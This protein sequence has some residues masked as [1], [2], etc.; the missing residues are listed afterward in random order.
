MLTD[1][2]KLIL[3]EN[4][5][6]AMDFY[7][8][9]GS[10][11]RIK[12]AKYDSTGLDSF[13][14]YLY[15][16]KVNNMIDEK[17]VLISLLGNTSYDGV[18]DIIANTADEFREVFVNTG[19]L[20]VMKLSSRCARGVAKHCFISKEVFLEFLA[21][22]KRLY[23]ILKLNNPELDSPEIKLFLKANE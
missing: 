14:A 12:K 7:A 17:Q 19:L 22:F 3:V 21:D 1:K 16:I 5:I 13:E 18:V 9:T 2:Q 20:A 11:I 10:I 23:N 15:L 6:K 8:C 4:Y